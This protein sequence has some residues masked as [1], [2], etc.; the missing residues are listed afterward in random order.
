VTSAF[1]LKINGATA[2]AG[3]DVIYAIFSGNINSA[4][5]TEAELNSGVALGAGTVGADG[6]AS[7]DAF[8]LAG[9]APSIPVGSYYLCV[10]L[11]PADVSEL[12]LYYA[13]LS[14]TKDTEVVSLAISD[15]TLE[16]S[17]GHGIGSVLDITITNMADPVINFTG[18]TDIASDTTLSVTVDGTYDEYRWFYNGT[19]LASQ[20]TSTCLFKPSD[21]PSLVRTGENSLMLV[22]TK[23]SLD[24]SATFPFNIVK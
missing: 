16:S 5:A 11:E 12:L 13:P 3:G 8:D 20:T 6:T 15:F 17:A 10:F 18:S 7:L 2:Y 21:F 22:V 1:T 24:Y 23:G 14:L 4:T 9:A 19:L